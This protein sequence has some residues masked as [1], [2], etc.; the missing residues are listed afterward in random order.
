MRSL[1]VD[2]HGNNFLRNNRQLRHTESRLEYLQQKVRTALSLFLGE[3][4]L[5]V[6][7]GIPYIPT[8][9]NR[10][11]HRTLIESRAQ[12]KIMAINGIRRLHRFATEFDSRNRTFSVSFVAETD[13]GEML[14]MEE[15]WNTG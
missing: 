3:W 11:A 6:S 13:A 8:T 4:F 7:L 14:E 2:P 9:D 5:D 10:S 1:A 15:T 12:T